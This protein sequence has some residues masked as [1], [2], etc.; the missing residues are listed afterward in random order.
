[1]RPR[2][3]PVARQDP[4]GG[5]PEDAAGASTARPRSRNC[6]SRWRASRW[7]CSRYEARASHPYCGD[8]AS[9]VLSDSRQP[10]AA[11]SRCSSGSAI[12]IVLWGFITRYLNTVTCGGLQL[13]AVAARGRPAVGLLHARHA[14]RDDGVLRGCLVAQLPEHLRVAALD[15]RVPGRP[16]ALEHRHQL[17][18]AGRDAGAGD[19]GLRAVVLHLRGAAG[20]RFC[21]CCSSSGSLWASSDARSCCGSAR[22]EWF[23]WPIP[24]LLSPFAG[25]FY[26]L[27]TLPHWM[28]VI[29]HLLPPRMFSKACAR[30]SSAGPL[31]RGNWRWLPCWP[32]FIYCWHAGFSS[33][34]TVT[35]YVRGLS[36]VTARKRWH[37]RAPAYLVNSRRVQ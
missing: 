20:R 3:V 32:F 33:A 35:Q 18:S 12:D 19:G 13:R 15:R 6:S 36:P 28:Q 21:W 11:V 8:R 26:P 2:A 14:R 34:S 16:G 17:R 5:Q 31:R 7:R 37:S 23:V 25:V 4:A 27:S 29:A 10:G 9:P 30:S 22:P 24:A 1:M